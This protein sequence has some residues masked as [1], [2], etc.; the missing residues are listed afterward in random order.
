MSRVSV[1]LV[2]DQPLFRE[3]LRTLLSVEPGIEVLGEAGD[4]EAAVQQ[5]RRLRPQV[6]LMDMRMPV[7]NGVEAT[8][9][10]RVETPESRVI[11]LTTFDDDEEVFDALTDVVCF[12]K[13]E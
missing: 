7:L 11:V 5:A 3:G 8:R 9:R 1:L 4:G 6:V 10:L 2:D 13:D 12:V